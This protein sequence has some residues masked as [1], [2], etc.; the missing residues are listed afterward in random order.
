M[1]SAPLIGEIYVG[2]NNRMCVLRPEDRDRSAGLN[3]APHGSVR[4]GDQLR[5]DIVC[6]VAL[7]V[8]ATRIVARTGA[9]YIAARDEH[10]VDALTEDGER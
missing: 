2:S 8:D 5:L 3:K 7:R 6:N 9:L 4:V 1:P 10:Q